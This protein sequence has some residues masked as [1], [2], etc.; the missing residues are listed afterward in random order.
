[1]CNQIKYEERLVP[2]CA[3]KQN[4]S[5][6]RN[7][8]KNATGKSKKMFIPTDKDGKSVVRCYEEYVASNACS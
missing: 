3:H 8:W 7:S 6:L 5:R 4:V 1:M 2:I